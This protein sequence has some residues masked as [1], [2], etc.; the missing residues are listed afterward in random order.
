MGKDREWEGR[1]HLL[2]GRGRMDGHGPSAQVGIIPGNDAYLHAAGVAGDTRGGNDDAGRNARE[3]H[4]NRTGFSGLP[5]EIGR[6]GGV[7]SSPDLD[8]FLGYLQNQLSRN[9]ALI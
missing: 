9:R 7:L 1:F 8:H 5:G 6:P 3:G 2:F 4:L